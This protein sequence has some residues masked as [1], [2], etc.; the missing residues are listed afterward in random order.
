MALAFLEKIAAVLV[1]A[2][3]SRG[4]PFYSP[5]SYI[6][7]HRAPC[8]WFLSFTSSCY[9]PLNSLT[10]GRS[11]IH[12]YRN[13]R[14]GAIAQNKRLF[15][16]FLHVFAVRARYTAVLE[17]GVAFIDAIK[18]MYEWSRLKPG[19]QTCKWLFGHLSIEY[20]LLFPPKKL[21]NFHVRIGLRLWCCF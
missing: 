3:H 17:K 20:F 8:I 4:S 12:R 6:P 16:S 2:H 1:R 13:V 9:T 11:Y 21:V 14:V 5:Y 18:G 10:C 19:N 7:W 15:A